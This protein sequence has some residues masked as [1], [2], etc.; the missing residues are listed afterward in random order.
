MELAG[1]NF[2]MSSPAI[3]NRGVNPVLPALSVAGGCGA[4]SR[5]GHDVQPTSRP[6]ESSVT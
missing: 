2:E 4:A 1:W 5:W 3:L 6:R